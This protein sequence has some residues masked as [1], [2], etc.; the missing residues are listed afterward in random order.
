MNQCASAE[1]A[2]PADERAGAGE[3]PAELIVLV[4]LPLS[5]DVRSLC[6]AACVARPW[7][8]AAS[9]PRVWLKIGPFRGPAAAHLTD[10]RLLS[11]VARVSSGGLRHLDLTGVAKSSLSDEGLAFALRRQ[12]GLLSFT[13]DGEPL[14]GAGIAAAL[15][16]SSGCLHRLG[17]RGVCAEPVPADGVPHGNQHAFW[18]NCIETLDTLQALLSPEGS[19]DADAVCCSKVQTRT[20]ATSMCVRVCGSEASCSACGATYCN[21][22]DRLHRYRCTSC[23]GG[24]CQRCATRVNVGGR[25]THCIC[26]DC[27]AEEVD[28]GYDQGLM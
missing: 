15:A 9:S 21:A 4:L 22:H 10:A 8:H 2:P 25:A 14:T 12:T 26:R 11:L 27:A 24:A 7:R 20:G 6:A 23:G 1:L 3:L 28:Y 17:V 16:P 5:G 13:A 18:T 19:T